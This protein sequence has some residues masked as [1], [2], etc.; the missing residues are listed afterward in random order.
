MVDQ[1]NSYFT[2]LNMKAEEV[3]KDLRSSQISRELE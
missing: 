2:D 3:V 1:F